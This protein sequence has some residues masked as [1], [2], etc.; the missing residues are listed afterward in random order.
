MRHRIIAIRHNYRVR[1]GHILVDDHAA[2][3]LRGAGQRLNFGHHN[4]IA[5]RICHVKH[6]AGATARQRGIDR[7]VASATGRIN[8]GADGGGSFGNRAGQRS[9]ICLTQARG[10]GVDI[11]HVVIDF[12]GVDFSFFNLKCRRSRLIGLLGLGKGADINL[13]VAIRNSTVDRLNLNAQPVL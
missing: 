13:A 6:D 1:V 10:S 8:R 9:T 4:R 2:R 12:E 5:G 11:D 3:R 7:G